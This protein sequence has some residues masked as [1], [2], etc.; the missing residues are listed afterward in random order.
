MKHY[1]LEESISN[2]MEDCETRSEA[3]ELLERW[4]AGF[5]KEE[6]LELLIRGQ[7]HAHKDERT[8]GYYDK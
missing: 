7:I 3:M 8:N 5:S 1:Y 2:L 4:A 6:L